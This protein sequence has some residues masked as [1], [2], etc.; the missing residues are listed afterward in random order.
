MT[1]SPPRSGILYGARDPGMR[2]DQT[3]RLNRLL[4]ELFFLV[5]ILHPGVTV[6]KH[7][8]SVS[9]ALAMWGVL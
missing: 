2:N 1:L 7:T 6:C 3:E 5:L 9:L 8:I 4:A